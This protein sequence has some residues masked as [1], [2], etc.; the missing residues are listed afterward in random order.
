MADRQTLTRKEH[1]KWP[2]HIEAASEACWRLQSPRMRLFWPLVFTLSCFFPFY[3]SY[4]QEHTYPL[5]RCS[6]PSEWVHSILIHTHTMA[7][8][9]SEGSQASGPSSATSNSYLQAINWLQ[10]HCDTVLMVAIIWCT[11]RGHLLSGRLPL[12]LSL[13]LFSHC[14]AQAAPAPIRRLLHVEA[15]GQFAGGIMYLHNCHS[16]VRRT[17]CVPVV[18]A[19]E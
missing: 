4:T 5:Y 1:L 3:P 6:C 15:N 2:R 12:L 11:R 17:S 18:A 9:A 8:W 19:R 16:T 14:P 7:K 10:E 13:S